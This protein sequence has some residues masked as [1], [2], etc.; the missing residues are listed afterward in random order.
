MGIAS[1]ESKLIMAYAHSSL[2]ILS[3]EKLCII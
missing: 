3:E 1:K 2:I